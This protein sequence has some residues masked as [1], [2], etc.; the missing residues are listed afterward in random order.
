E[1][2]GL[3]QWNGKYRPMAVDDVEAKEERNAE[4]R[5]FHGE[6]L[7][8]VRFLGAPVIEE[9]SD[10]AGSNPR[11]DILKRCGAGDGE[12]RGNHVQL[13]DLFVDR[14]CGQQRI[15]ASRAHA[16]SIPVT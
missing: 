3:S 15:D 11:P 4:A 10:P 14:H 13:A 7:D 8:F 6:S 2:A 12:S 1:G 5:F 9:A 16:F